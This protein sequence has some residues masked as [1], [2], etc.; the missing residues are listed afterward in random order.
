[1]S[2]E[3][4]RAGLGKVVYTVNDAPD[5]ESLQEDPSG[6]AEVERA[7][8]ESFPASDPPSFAGGT[9]PKSDSD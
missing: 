5:K 3:K 6:R 8:R 2:N 4:N 7:D 9:E 1:M